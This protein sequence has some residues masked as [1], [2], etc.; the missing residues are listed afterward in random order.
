MSDRRTTGVIAIAVFT[1]A[2]ALNLTTAAPTVVEGDGAEL[3]TVAALGG[4]AHPTGYPA[5]T[6]CGRL[7]ALAWP[8]EPARR[9]TALSAV[10]GA[11]AL[12]VLVRVV[13]SLGASP[14]VILSAVVL[15]GAGVTLRWA[16][17]YPEVYALAALLHLIALERVIRAARQPTSG[18]NAVAAAALSLSGTSHFLFAPIS[19]VLALILLFRGPRDVPALTRRAAALAA[20]SVVGFLPYLYTAWADAAGLPMNYLRLVVEPGSGMFG[21]TPDRFDSSWER[22]GWLVFGA[23]TR[24]FPFYLHP[25]LFAL[26]ASDALAGQFLF[27]AGPAALVLAPLG[28]RAL[29]RR[30]AGVATTVLLIAGTSFLFAASVSQGRMQ[31]PFLLPA[32]I[33]IGSLSAFGAGR[34]ASALTAGAASGVLAVLIASAAAFLPHAIRVHAGDHPIGPRRWR[35]AVEG[36]PALEGLL[37]RLD[38]ATESRRTGERAL[39]LIPPGA[40][41]IGRWR[42]LMTLYYL[43]E[44]EGR[45]RDLTFDPVYRGHEPR[46]ARWQSD[47]DVGERPFVLLGRSPEIE[48]YLATLDSIAVTDRLT[49]YIQREPM[50]GLPA[51]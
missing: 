11:A 36:G 13:A 31:L 32:A 6:L 15:V 44:V 1:A 34:L 3:Q 37:P 25:R 7:F 10:A 41:V 16:S 26:N 2:L 17:L 14:G 33:A 29:W 39:D 50:R 21:L 42:E 47:H 4:V 30:H 23:E 9:A 28:A 43:R 22:I 35:F 12:A 49:L 48:P 19:V 40:L 45:R 8:G 27:D 51:P 38:A 18:R 24:L 46:Y 20:G 5:W